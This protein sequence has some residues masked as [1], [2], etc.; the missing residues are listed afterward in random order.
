MQFILPSVTSAT[1]AR[2]TGS[3]QISK[4]LAGIP[5]SADYSQEE[6]EF[7]IEL[8]SAESGNPISGVYSSTITGSDS[9]ESYG[10]IKSGSSIKLHANETATISGLPTGTFYRVTEL[11]HNGYHV[12]VNNAVGFVA[13]GHISD[14]GISPAAFINEPYY[15]LPQTGGSGTTWY[16]AGGA[17]LLGCAGMLLLYQ[18][19]KHRKEPF[20]S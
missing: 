18:K 19:R 6:Y 4:K 20:S 2:D 15:E 12:K 9:K 1:T 13:S 14:G 3:L 5:D 7:Q 16:T 17:L 8:L 11:T 10:V